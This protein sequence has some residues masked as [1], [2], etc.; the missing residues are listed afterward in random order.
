MVRR[1]CDTP[2]SMVVRCSIARS[3]RHFHFQECRRRAPDLARA[4]RAEIRR[5]AALAERLGGVGEPH[6]RPDLVA[7]EQDG[8]EEHTSEVPP[9]RQENPRIRIVGVGAPRE[10]AHDGVVKLDPDFDDRRAADRIDPERQTDLLADLVR[11][12]RVE[13][14]EERLRSGRRQHRLRQ[15]I[16]HEIQPVLRDAAQ[17]RHDL[18]PADRFCRRRSGSRSPASRR[19]TDSQ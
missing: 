6:D 17:L 15:E 1:S 14:R 16:D 9:S 8:D 18:R 13:L 5:L 4:A 11:Q 2:A 7:Q 19:T 12:R 10:H 3:M